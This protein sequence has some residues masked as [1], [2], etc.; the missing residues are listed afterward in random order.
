LKQSNTRRAEFGQSITIPQI[1][2]GTGARAFGARKVHVKLQ[3][4]PPAPRSTRRKIFGWLVGVAAV[5]VIL[6]IFGSI[7]ERLSDAQTLGLYALGI[8]IYFVGF[9]VGQ[10]DERKSQEYYDRLKAEG[11]ARRAREEALNSNSPIVNA[12]VLKPPKS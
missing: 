2:E 7:T 8:L 10:E 3:S 12:D 4:S 9:V 6:W 11:D 5:I 1:P